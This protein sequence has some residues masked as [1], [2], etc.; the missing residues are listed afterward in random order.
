MTNGEIASG[1]IMLYIMELTVKHDDEVYTTKEL[2]EKCGCE[3][4]KASKIALQLYRETKRLD[5]IK[6]KNTLYYGSPTAI[7][8]LRSLTSSNGSSIGERLFNR[9]GSKQK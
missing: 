1:R 7:S 3:K 9:G 8:T 6:I 5:R 2:A 4:K